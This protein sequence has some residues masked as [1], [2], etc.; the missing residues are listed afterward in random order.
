MDSNSVIVTYLFQ[1]HKLRICFRSF[2]S[3]KILV[4]FMEIFIDRELNEE[5]FLIGSH[6]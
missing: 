2:I 5:S 6:F 1:I 4:L 3:L